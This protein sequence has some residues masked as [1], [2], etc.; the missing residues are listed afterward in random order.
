MTVPHQKWSFDEKASD[1]DRPSIMSAVRHRQDISSPSRGAMETGQKINVYFKSSLY[2]S[3]LHG[4]VEEGARRKGNHIQG[5]FS[6]W[7]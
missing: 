4:C 7:Y 2:D 3:R 5:T 6:K 1:L